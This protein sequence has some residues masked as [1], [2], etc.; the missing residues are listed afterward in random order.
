M[1]TMLLPSTHTRYSSLPV[2]GTVLEDLCSWLEAH[3]YPANAITRRIQAAPFLDQCLQRRHVQSLSG[4][5]AEQL[6]A[7]FP[8]EDRWTP[9]IAYSLGRSLLS[10]LEERGDLAST[11]TASERLIDGYRQHLERVRGFATSTIWRHADL[12]S[13]FLRFLAYED[14]LQR[15]A[16]IQPVDLERF[17]GEASARVGRIT[18][19]KVIAIMRSFLRFLSASGRAPVR[20]DQYLESPRYYRGQHL[21]RAL[22]WD[23]V[24]SILRAIDLSTLKGRRDYAMLL[25][26]ATYGLRRGEV[27]SLTLD[28][29]QWRARVIRVPRPKVGTPLAVPLTDEVATA[30]LAYLHDRA[31]EPGTRQLF[32]RVRAPQGPILSSA[33]G[34]A[35]DFWAAR[36]GV[37]MP[38]L[39]GPH[40]LRHGVAMNLL[41]RGTS[42]KTIGDLLGHRNV[43]STGIYLRLQIEDLRDVALPLPTRAC[44]E[45]RP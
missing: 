5:T 37:R 23:K 13:D 1:L 40:A 27:A 21:V 14:N 36:A 26:I 31:A 32:L 4:Y 8:R 3:G 28:D 34:D 45:V 18:M 43:E 42:L 2:L 29:I 38:G 12:A 20:L 15:L 41:R 44:P 10:Y 19:Q 33:V 24:L 35:F 16:H 7:C 6:R 30:L 17:I 11:P 25:L 22:P 9:Q 39:G